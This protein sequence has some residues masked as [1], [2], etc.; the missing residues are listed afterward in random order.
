GLDRHRRDPGRRRRV[1][2]RAR[3]RADRAGRAPPRHPGRG[4]GAG[5]VR[6]APR[7]VRRVGLTVL[8][9]VVLHRAGASLARAVEVPDLAAAGRAVAA[10]AVPYALLAAAGA[11]AA[12][13]A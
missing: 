13:T 4:D 5:P 2:A 8:A 10:L 1:A 12:G 11:A 7:R 9:S 6:A 3:R